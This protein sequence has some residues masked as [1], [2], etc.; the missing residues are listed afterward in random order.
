MFYDILDQKRK[1]IPPHLRGLKGNTASILD[2]CCMKLAAIVSRA[3]M[4]DYVDLYFIFQKISL[5][6]VLKALAEKMPELDENLVRKSL[7]YYKDLENEPIDFKHG[8][9]ADLATIENY[10]KELI[11]I[12]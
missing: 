6:R 7:V 4:K 12:K 11:K 5:D 8:N 10:F 1:G 9:E 2:I 3:T